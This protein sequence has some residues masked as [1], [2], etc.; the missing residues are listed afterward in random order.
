MEN[1]TYK[2]SRII[3][4]SALI[5]ALYAGLTMALAPISFGPVQFRVAEALTLLPF[6]VPEAVPG[7]FV[8]C[9]ISNLLGGFGLADV[10]LGSLATLAAAWMTS[11]M[12]NVWLAAVPPV[13]V[14][15]AVVGVYLSFLT[16]TPLLLSVVYIALSQ[17]VVCFCIGVPLAI[18]VSRSHVLDAFRQKR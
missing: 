1:I 10:V 2:P 4:L 13:A 17:S 8:G 11:R 5:A 9:L 18:Y 16:G 15:A 6:L 14:N 3:A 12:P 7:L